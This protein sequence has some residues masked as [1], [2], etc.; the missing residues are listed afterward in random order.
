VKALQKGWLDVLKQMHTIILIQY[1][2][3]V[4][5]I[6]LYLS[7]KCTI[8]LLT[9]ICFLQ[10]CYMFRCL[11]IILKDFVFAEVTD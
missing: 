7:N 9:I 10:H 11:Y 2:L 1:V 5:Y 4:W 6:L 8:H 3:C